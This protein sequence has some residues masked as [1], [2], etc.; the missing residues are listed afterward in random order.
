MS[1]LIIKIKKKWRCQLVEENH[2][3]WHSSQ[4][5][6]NGRRILSVTWQEHWET[7]LRGK[8]SRASPQTHERW[9]LLFS[10]QTP[11]PGSATGTPGQSS[12]QALHVSDKSQAPNTFLPW[13]EASQG[14]LYA[15]ECDAIKRARTTRF[16]SHNSIKCHVTKGPCL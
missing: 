8:I 16:Y 2:Y 6:G 11:D 10:H 7:P 14:G 5:T 12:M 9:A 13:K 15:E 4:Q 3:L 1:E